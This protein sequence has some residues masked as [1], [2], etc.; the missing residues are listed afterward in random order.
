MQK[1]HFILLNVKRIVFLFILILVMFVNTGLVEAFASTPRTSSTN[2]QTENREENNRSNSGSASGEAM[3]GVFRPVAVVVSNALGA[4]PQHG[5]SQADIIYETLV[6]GGITRK[7]AIF[8]DIT[9]VGTLG[10]IRSA[11]PYFIDIAESHDAIF[12]HGGGSPLAISIL[13]S[14]NSCHIDGVFGPG[15]SAF[16]REPQRIQIHSLFT[17]GARISQTVNSLGIRPT[18]REGF[19]PSLEFTGN[20]APVTQTNE[21]QS[22]SGSGRIS[23]AT[24]SGVIE[25]PRGSGRADE[26]SVRFSASNTT[27][28]RY[29]IND[30]LYYVSHHN[31]Q[32]YTDGNN[33][34]QVAVSNIIILKTSVSGIPGDGAGRLNIVTTGSGTGYFA[35]GGSFTEIRWSRSGSSAQFEYSL[36]DGTPLM[37]GFGTTYICI[38]PTDARIRIN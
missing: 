28:F 25:A 17:S 4:L 8:N 11:R 20:A 37:L 32:R 10:S 6:E 38:V 7:L 26:I 15:L 22:T 30:N 5:I 33:D 18:H 1:K 34:M 27:V 36:L 14:R 23:S 9:G 31:N 35:N 24:T 13:Q 12:V 29:D 2:T 19:R 21:S 3:S 16:Y